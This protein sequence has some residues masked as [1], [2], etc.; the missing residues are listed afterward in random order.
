MDEFLRKD[1]IYTLQLKAEPLDVIIEFFTYLNNQF[2]DNITKVFKFDG[3][4][5]YK[6]KKINKYCREMTL[7]KY[8]F[9]LTVQK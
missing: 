4:K 9:I 8:I 2:K 3:G 6:N 1:W 7:K 5:G